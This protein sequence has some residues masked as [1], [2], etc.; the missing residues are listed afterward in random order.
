MRVT[1][2]QPQYFPRLHYFNRILAADVFVILDSTQYTK[3]LVH[4]N[5]ERKRHKSYQAD[6]P[7]KLSQGLHVLTVPVMHQGTLPINKTRIDYTHHWVPKHLS[8]VRTAYGRAPYF[9][10]VFPQVQELLSQKDA[11]LADLNIKTILWGITLVLDLALPL[12]KLSLAAINQRL[13]ETKRARLKRIMRVDETGVDRP[14]GPGKGSQWTAAICRSLQATEYLHGGTA[15]S[16]YMDLSVY[17]QAGVTPIIQDWHCPQYPQQFS[18]TVGFV[19]NLSVLD[20][21]FNVDSA[22]ARSVLLS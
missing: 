4:F 9:A 17:R 18:D 10:S 19:G 16:G 7:I 11:V 1:I 3:S 22:T 8:T 13:K 6:A 12:E 14:E 15:Q 20:L 2:Y 21:A 5:G